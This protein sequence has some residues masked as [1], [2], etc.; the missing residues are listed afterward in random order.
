MQK[1]NGNVNLKMSWM[2]DNQEYKENLHPRIAKS[3]SKS[4]SKQKD[5][6]LLNNNN[7]NNYNNHNDNNKNKTQQGFSIHIPA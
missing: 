5:R 7:N 2:V 4:K 6:N 1:S 3:K